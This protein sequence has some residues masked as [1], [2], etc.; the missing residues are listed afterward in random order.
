[1]AINSLQHM[2]G[3]DGYG[4]DPMDHLVGVSLGGLHRCIG[5]STLEFGCKCKEYSMV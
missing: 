5:F 2:E 3:T 1:M 4:K